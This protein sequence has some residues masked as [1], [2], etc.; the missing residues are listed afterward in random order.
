MNAMKERSFLVT[1]TSVWQMEAGEKARTNQLSVGKKVGTGIPVINACG[2]K[3]A[4]SY[5]G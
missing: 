5:P 4:S 2:T 3:Q 1:P